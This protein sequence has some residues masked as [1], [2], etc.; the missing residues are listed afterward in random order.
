MLY[1][2][3]LINIDDF[4]KE[5][6]ITNMFFKENITDEIRTK[7]INKYKF[8]EGI[9]PLIKSNSNEIEYIYYL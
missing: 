6:N 9:T 4:N 7:I 2:R 8:I 5:L 1:C 3:E